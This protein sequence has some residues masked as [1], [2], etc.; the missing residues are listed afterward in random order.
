MPGDTEDA[1]SGQV[2]ELYKYKTAF[3]NFIV[4]VN[5]LISPSPILAVP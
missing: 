3:E 5:L 2:L 1:S 4:S